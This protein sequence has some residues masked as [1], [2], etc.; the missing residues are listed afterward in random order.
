[1]NYLQSSK[2]NVHQIAKQLLNDGRFNESKEIL[3][4]LLE[5]DPSDFL[6]I[7]MLGLLA[8]K[9]K[10]WNLAITFFT[11]AIETNRNDFASYLERGLINRK[12][13]N[14]PSSISDFSSALEINPASFEALNNR[15]I[16]HCQAGNSAQAIID[17]SEAIAL[18]PDCSQTYFNRG[19]AQRIFG[20]TNAALDDYTRSIEL[21]SKNYRALNNRAMLHRDLKNFDKAIYDLDQ[22]LSVQPD[23]SEALW[24]KSLTLLLV[25]EY[26]LGWELYE[27][28]WSTPD[29]KSKARNFSSPLWL[30]E[31][32]LKNKTIFIHSEQGLGDTLQFC[33]Y[34]NLFKDLSCTVLLEVERPLVT[35]MYSL[36]PKENIFEKGTQLPEFDYHCPMMSLPLA[37]KTIGITQIENGPYLRPNASAVAR[38]SSILGKSNKTRIG[39]A[40]RG[41]PNHVKNRMR[42]IELREL[43]PRLSRRF[44]WISLEI[45]PSEEETDLMQECGFIRNFGQEIGDFLSTSALCRNLHAVVSVD[46]SIAHLAGSIGTQVH[47]LL[48]YIPDFRWQHSG[49]TT[50]WY[51]NMV[52]YRQNEDRD[53]NPIINDVNNSLLAN[54]K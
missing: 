10:Q 30:G 37:F 23:F 32:S 34:I 31:N 5:E 52:L 4:K 25:G 28:R 20:H 54:C 42:S 21:D 18:K 41:N 38:W 27:S 39:L 8:K 43:I 48:P 46:T 33:R 49:R 29:F 17:F 26:D 50:H 35:A 22:C 44:D 9:A 6:A 47:L 40:W 1:M 53:W 11:R 45:N 7:H 15:G 14:L 16:S 19:L 3:T 12:L 36:L 24:N 13:A 2:T 51:P